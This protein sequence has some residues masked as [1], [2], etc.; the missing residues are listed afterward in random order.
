VVN[1]TPRPSS[2]SN[3]PVPTLDSIVRAI[4]TLRFTAAPSERVI[5]DAIAGAFASHY[6]VPFEHEHRLGPGNV[7][8]FFVPDPGVGIEV[9]KGK[10]GSTRR[11]MEQVERYAG[12]EE[13]RAMVIVVE[14]K[15]H[16]HPETVN[17]KT[18]VY[19]GL[20]KLWGVAL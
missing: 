13:I 18:L 8:D 10:P 19:I 16:W 5:K 11:V 20:A 17:G 9:K 6:I 2:A 3:A 4:R 15:L 12:F 14:G 7:V 1:I